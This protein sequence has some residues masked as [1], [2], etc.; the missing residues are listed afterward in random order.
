MVKERK[1]SVREPELSEFFSDGRA[2]NAGQYDF[3]RFQHVHGEPHH[4]HQ[5]FRLRDNS[6]SGLH[7]VPL[8]S[9]GDAGQ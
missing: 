8:R 4:P 2:G 6:L 3:T 1:R 9:H 7:S 5:P